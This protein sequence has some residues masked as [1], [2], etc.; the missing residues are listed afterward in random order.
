MRVCGMCDLRERNRD[1]NMM[2]VMM[3]GMRDAQPHILSC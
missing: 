1:Q 3:K 2:M